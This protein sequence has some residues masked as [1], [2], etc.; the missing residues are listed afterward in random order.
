MTFPPKSV[1]ADT[2][3]PARAKGDIPTPRLEVAWTGNGQGMY[4]VNPRRF[5]QPEEWVSCEQNGVFHGDFRLPY[6]QEL[7]R[8]PI[9]RRTG[10]VFKTSSY[11]RGGVETT[12]SAVRDNARPAG[13]ETPIQ[14]RGVGALLLC[15]PGDNA[16]YS[17]RFRFRLTSPRHQSRRRGHLSG[18]HPLTLESQS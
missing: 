6:V 18:S 14:R 4:G 3:R 8:N 2:C 5:F 16:R 9:P 13:I 15:Y 17:R 7:S 10:V 12:A 11:I 1:P